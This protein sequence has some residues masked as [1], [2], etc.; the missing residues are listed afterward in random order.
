[1]RTRREF[2]TWTG[3]ALGCSW[4]AGSE[5]HAEGVETRPSETSAG[6]QPAAKTGS[7]VG[8]LFPFIQSQAVKADFPLSFLRDEFKDLPIWKQ[9]ARGK[10]LELLHYAPPKCN[11]RPE[12]AE[13]TD[14]GDYVRE[15]I[16]FNTTP[17]LRVPAYVLIP[18]KGKRPLPA[19]VALHDHG[20][21][22]LWGKEKLVETEDEHSVLTKFKKESY[23]GHSIATDLVRRGYLVIVIDMFYWGE[24]RMLLDDD[25]PPHNAPAQ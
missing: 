1:M 13:K 17:D 9:R 7:D 11:P 6:S 10:L 23:A 25:P 12:L 21:F 18:K 4:L 5:A 2:I 22:Y 19:I 15:K 20:G 14:Q 16:Y 3:A 8:S 24:R